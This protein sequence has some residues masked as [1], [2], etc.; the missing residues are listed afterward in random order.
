[1]NAARVR[2]VKG[3]PFAHMFITGIGIGMNATRGRH[4]IKLTLTH[5]MKLTLT[6]MMKHTLTHMMNSNKLTLNI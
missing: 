1:M 3:T 6:Q 5:M 2:R 4:M